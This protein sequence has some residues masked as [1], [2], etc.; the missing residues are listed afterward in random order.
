MVLTNL[1]SAECRILETYEH[2]TYSTSLFTA[3]MN[4]F[5]LII[6]ELVKIVDAKAEQGKKNPAQSG[7][8]WTSV[9]Q[10]G[11]LL[12]GLILL[13]GSVQ[14]IALRSRCQVQILNF[15]SD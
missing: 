2:H 15:E 1:K 11:L 9:L 10:G 12:L 7:L 13:I 5:G 8:I 14:D 6:I 4:I 3:A